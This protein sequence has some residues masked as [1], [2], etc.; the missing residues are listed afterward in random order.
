MI[1][2]L[3]LLLV[4]LSV[5]RADDIPSAPSRGFQSLSAGAL[6]TGETLIILTGLR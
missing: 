2:L 4:L 3:L 5:A 6:Y 1:R